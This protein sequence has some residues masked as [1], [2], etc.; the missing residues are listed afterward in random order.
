MISQ[1]KEEVIEKNG[2]QNVLQNNKKNNAEKNLKS[3]TDTKK[4]NTILSPFTIKYQCNFI[5]IRGNIVKDRSFCETN[6]LNALLSSQNPSLKNSE[7]LINTK[8]EEIIEIEANENKK[9]KVEEGL[10]KEVEK[11]R[12]ISATGLWDFSNPNVLSVK[13]SNGMVS[14]FQ[15]LLLLFTYLFGYLLIHPFGMMSTLFIITSYFFFNSFLFMI[16][17]FFSFHL[18]FNFPSF[19]RHFFFFR[20]FDRPTYFFILISFLFLSLFLTVLFSTSS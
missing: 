17:V 8:N 16:F 12:R 4:I 9:I 6:K 15:L 7:K 3:N 19:T 10:E 14:F 18:F 2:D 5:D 11:G 13:M 20:L 1:E